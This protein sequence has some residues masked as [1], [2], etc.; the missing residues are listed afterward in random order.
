MKLNIPTSTTGYY[1][2]K[3]G[4]RPKKN[5]DFS[6]TQYFK[7][8]KKTESNQ[9]L[10]SL[11]SKALGLKEIIEILKPGNFRDA[12]FKLATIKLLIELSKDLKLTPEELKLFNESFK[13]PL[14]TSKQPVH[15]REKTE[16][17]SPSI[18]DILKEEKRRLD[19]ESSERRANLKET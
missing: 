3:F 19:A 1:Y 16:K 13:T 14:K 4:K 17:Q 6:Y 5:N 10:T 11:L 7:E 9:T 18:K 12:Y 2:G 8:N 15:A